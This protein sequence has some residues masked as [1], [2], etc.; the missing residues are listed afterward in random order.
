MSAFE[1][2]TR[3]GPLEALVE[4][5]AEQEHR[6]DREERQRARDRAE[7]RQV[8][9]EELRKAD[10]EER[11]PA[12]PQR[13]LPSPQADV[14]KHEAE[15]APEGADRGVAA[16][17]VRRDVAWADPLGELEDRK[18]QAVDGEARREP[19]AQDANARLQTVEFFVESI[20]L[21]I[22]R[23]AGEQRRGEDR[24]HERGEAR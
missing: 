20:L 2:R 14:E 12:D 21:R 13:R 6:T 24:K 18:R 1:L 5:A 15:H 19:E 17:E 4:E 11:H 9:E 22:I 23:R 3:V 8:V 7:P 10:S 16:L